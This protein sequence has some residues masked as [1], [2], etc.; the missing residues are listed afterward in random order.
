VAT[1]AGRVVDLIKSA[2]KRSKLSEVIYIGLNLL[3]ALLLFATSTQFDPPYIAYV[4]VLLS[5]WRVLAVRPRFWF[6]NIQAN[7]L[8]VLVGFSVITL[9]WQVHSWGA[10]PAHVNFS[11]S[12]LL[13]ELLVAL[14]FA[15]WLLLIKPKSKRQWVVW[16]AGIAQFLA[17]TA[18]MSIGYNWPS[19]VVVLAGWLIGYITARHVLSSYD[20][21]ELGL[22]SLVWGL[23]I[24]ELSWLAYH[25]SIAYVFAYG[26]L[27]IPQISVIIALIGYMTLRIYALYHHGRKNDTKVRLSRIRGSLIFVGVSIA[28]LLV[29]FGGLNGQ[30]WE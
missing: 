16:Q 24:A 6:A 11:L 23:L 13:V 29:F 17:I 15:V 1:V 20:E 27:M 3:F 7:I 4:L 25:W 9:L 5:K 22:M 19:S 2:A 28:I 12:A 30:F 26:A 8:D 21:N 10:I 14:F 18:L